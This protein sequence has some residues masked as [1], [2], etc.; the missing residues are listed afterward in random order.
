MK[1]GSESMKTLARRGLFWAM[2]LVIFAA[3]FQGSTFLIHSAAQNILQSGFVT[4][5][6]A[7]GVVMMVD[8]AIATWLTV[9]LSKWVGAEW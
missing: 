2:W 6:L 3:V 5:I 4:A 1:E 9:K 7:T 8:P